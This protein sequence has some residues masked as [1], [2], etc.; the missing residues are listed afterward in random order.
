VSE[1][2]NNAYNYVPADF[3]IPTE[4]TA[5]RLWLTDYNKKIARALQR[6]DLGVFSISEIGA[7]LQYFPTTVGDWRNVWRLVVD[8]GALPDTTSKSVAHGLTWDANNPLIFT[9]I[10]ATATDGTGFNAVPIPDGTG[11]SI[12]VDA[13]NVTITTVADYSDY[14]AYVVLEYIKETP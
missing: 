8:F 5:A 14:S 7:G 2:I 13:T 12:A 3:E 6:R 9:H 11:N 10:Y 1:P 4:S